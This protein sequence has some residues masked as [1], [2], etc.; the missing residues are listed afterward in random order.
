MC[1]IVV[2]HIYYSLMHLHAVKSP[3][4]YP[5]HGHITAESAC[6]YVHTAFIG[7]R[8]KK[9]KN[10]CTRTTHDRLFGCILKSH[11]P[12][13]SNIR[14]HASLKW[15]KTQASNIDWRVS[16]Q[17]KVKDS[18]ILGSQILTDRTAITS[19]LFFYPLLLF[20]L[21]SFPLKWT[22]LSDAGEAEPHCGKI[23]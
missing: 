7:S 4:F 6:T 19:S 8:Y 23:I 16:A 17:W 13:Y 12:K 9:N 10:T 22:I 14:A 1:L 15:K 21:L 11:Y 5:N 20:G 3:R 2:I 18:S